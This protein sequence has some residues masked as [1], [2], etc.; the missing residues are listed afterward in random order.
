MLHYITLDF[1]FHWILSIPLIPGWFGTQQSPV[2]CE[3]F[4]VDQEQE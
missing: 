2:K 3:N 1:Y 4:Y